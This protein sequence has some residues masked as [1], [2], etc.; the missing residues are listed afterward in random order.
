MQGSGRRIRLAAAIFGLLAALGGAEPARADPLE[1]S[2]DLDGL[3]L[4]LGP[5]GGAIYHEGAWGAGF[6]GE[7]T[8][9]RVAEREPVAALG[10]AVGGLRFADRDAGHLWA[11]LSIGTRWPLD[12]AVGLSVG[13]TV[14]V[15]EVIPPRFGGHATI[16]LFV[17]VVPYLRVGAVETSGRFVELGVKLALPAIRL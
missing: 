14:E 3:Y 2:A 17:G 5:L 4:A 7:V 6:G 9:V 10:A 11:D 13:P 12:L 16:W 15:D 8:V 1:S